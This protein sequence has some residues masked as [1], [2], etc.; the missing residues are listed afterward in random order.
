MEYWIGQS[1]KLL[2][3]ITRE[4]FSRNGYLNQGSV[5]VKEVHPS[6]RTG[7]RILAVS[8]STGEK[9]VSFICCLLFFKLKESFASHF[10]LLLIWK[11][12]LPA[13]GCQRTP[14]NSPVN[15][16]TIWLVHLLEGVTVME[17]GPVRSLDVMVSKRWFEREKLIFTLTELTSL[18]SGKMHLLGRL[19]S[20][21]VKA[22]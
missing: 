22:I 10:N 13:L 18:S 19:V 6:Y 15:E 12:T 21:Q 2:P 4:F 5:R 3:T 20:K 16:A 1:L 11:W 17:S 8:S 9:F 7:E 14:V